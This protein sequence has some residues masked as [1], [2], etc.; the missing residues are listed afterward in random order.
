MRNDIWKTEMESLPRQ[1]SS[2]A[3]S[4]L[5]LLRKE[6]QSYSVSSLMY[7][8]A[9]G[10]YHWRIL[11]EPLELNYITQKKGKDITTQKQCGKVKETGSNESS[12]MFFCLLK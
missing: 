8:S 7:M 11:A 2:T 6:K 10:K 1:K 3:S 4:L 12:R 9:L 5:S